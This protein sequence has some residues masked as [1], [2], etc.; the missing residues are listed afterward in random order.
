MRMDFHR[1]LDLLRTDTSAMCGLAGDAVGRA[2]RGLLDTDVEMARRVVLDVE[3]LRNMHNGVER[4]T[5]TLLAR[6]APVARDLRTVVSAIHVAADADRMGGLALHVARLCLR[7]HPESPIP[8]ELREKFREMGRL[9][10][11]LAERCRVALLAGDCGQARLVRRDDQ[12]M[13]TL[14][15]ELFS[16]VM[17]P[18][19]P[20]GAGV[21]ADVVLLGRFYGRFADHAEG[22]AQRLIFEANGA[23]AD[24]E[25]A[26]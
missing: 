22:I 5:L 13:E 7:Y 9:A 2:T 20:H 4:R 21:A 23:P 14:H 26:V 19:W 16:A 12:A 6:Q 17:S 1:Q 3:R 25:Q 18:Q 8:E 24:R 10:V 11:E 15:R